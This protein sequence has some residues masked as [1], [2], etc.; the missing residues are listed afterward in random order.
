M[1]PWLM[2]TAGL[3][4]GTALGCT[5]AILERAWKRARTPEHRDTLLLDAVQRHRWH[6][7]YLNDRFA[8]LGDTP[9]R[10]LGGPNDDVRTV[11]ASAMETEHATQR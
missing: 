3:T 4:F 1:N 2:F 11:I 5:I 9:P 6:I 7:G 8:L 10:I